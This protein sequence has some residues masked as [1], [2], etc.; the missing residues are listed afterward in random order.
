MQCR[1]LAMAPR[2]VH[3]ERTLVARGKIASAVLWMLL[4][5]RLGT[6]ACAMRRR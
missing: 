4:V 5:Y 2:L 3:T 6:N 1:S